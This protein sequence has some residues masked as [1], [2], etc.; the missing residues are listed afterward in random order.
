MCGYVVGNT[1][2]TDIF[3]IQDENLEYR[4]YALAGFSVRQEPLVKAVGRIAELSSKADK[5]EGQLGLT[6][7]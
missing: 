2:A 5:V 4:G 3:L 6:Y 7:R 1:N